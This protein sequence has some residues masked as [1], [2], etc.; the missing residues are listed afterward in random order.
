[1][2]T[3]TESF[4][5]LELSYPERQ[6]VVVLDDAVV[7]ATRKAAEAARNGTGADW[8]AVVEKIAQGVKRLDTIGPLITIAGATYDEL[9]AWAKAREGGLNILQ[10]GRSEAGRLRFPPGH[11]RDRALY[12]AHPATPSVYY[13]MA[14]FHRMAFEHKFS[15][16]V[17]LLMS[18]G[19]TEIE[20]EHIQGWDRKFT[21]Q[22]S[23]PLQQ[24]DASG[25]ASQSTGRKSSLLFKAS[26]D[27]KQ[28]AT[29]PEGLV[30][31]AH[32]PTWQVLADGRIK[33]GLHEFSLAVN[34]EDDFGV[35]AGMKLR[36]QKAGLDIGG[37]FEDHVATTWKLTGKFSRGQSGCA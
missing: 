22:M 13:T 20:V 36:V 16:A 4:D 5:V 17:S 34:Y 30:W 33:Y 31:F 9:R 27:N 3:Q 8:T 29:V 18:L 19:A 11:P 1:M 37:T 15:E 28:D 25:H 14:S 32:E 6:L 35:N 23:V 10:V 21:S 2:S 26:Y 7:Q 24:V 12:V